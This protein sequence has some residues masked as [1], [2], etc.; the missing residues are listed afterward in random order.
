MP[1][2]TTETMTREALRK[3]LVTLKGELEIKC[4][5]RVAAEVA[6]YLASLPD[7]DSTQKLYTILLDYSECVVESLV[8][9]E[10]TPKWPP[11]TPVITVR[12]RELT[13]LLYSF[14]EVAE[15]IFNASGDP[16]GRPPHLPQPKH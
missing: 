10:F 3:I 8:D 6:K 7:A 11:K 16:M 9:F 13:H 1:T 14:I 12:A 2:L 15:D 4:S 5:P